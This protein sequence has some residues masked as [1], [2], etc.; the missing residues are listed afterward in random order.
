[1]FVDEVMREIQDESWARPLLHEIAANDGLTRAN[2]AKFFELRFGYSLHQ[3]G[4][5]PRYEV[6]G[7]G[8]STIDFG[9][10]A[11][12]REWLVELMRLEE[13]EA[14]HRATQIETDDQEITWSWRILST[15]AAD[16]RHSEEGETLKAVER[17]CQKCDRSGHAHKFPIPNKKLHVLLVD[18]RTFLFGG[19][20]HDRIHVALGGAY[21]ND[22]NCRRY[23][24]DQLIT[25]VFDPHT[26][27]RGAIETRQRVHLLGFVSEKSYKSGHSDR[28]PNLLR[29]CNYSS[30]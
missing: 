15:T 5:S 20:I 28:A 26:K 7:E 18:F 14:V 2:K 17:I 19:D 10:E 9:F 13:T 27:V 4:I 23:W 1:M 25:G 30:H 29:T 3:L 6:E 24:N 16:A 21:V 8:E 22:A 12:G 11:N